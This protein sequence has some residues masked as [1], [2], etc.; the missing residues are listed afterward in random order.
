MFVVLLSGPAWA[1]SDEEKSG[2]RA[3]AAEGVRAMSEQRWAEAV[4]LFTRAEALVHSPMHLLYI[5]RG[6]VQLGKL[7]L[8]REA[9]VKASRERI[10]PDSPAAFQRARDEAQQELQALQPRLPHLTVKVE[11]AD[12]KAVVVKMDGAVIPTPLIGVPHPVDPG[13]HRLEAEGERILSEP[14]LV[15]IAEGERLTT[16]IAVK[17]DPT[18]PAPTEEVESTED[19]AADEGTTQQGEKTN[20][21]RLAS[22]GAAGVGVVGLAVGTIFGLKALSNRSDA[23][24]ACEPQVDGQCPLSR[25]SEIED[26]D[27]SANSASTLSIVGFV[28]GGVGLAAGGTLFFLSTRREADPATGA[29][30]QPWL[31]VGSAGVAGRF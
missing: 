1:A 10:T 9:F 3:A 14:V 31:G 25:Q 30:I 6:N 24:A 12:P 4:D 8:A 5:G 16:T 28:V 7:V 23:D 13:E 15:K 20:V 17:V 18:A 27:A 29:S 11:G 2:A 26:L 21:L 22:Y 19:I